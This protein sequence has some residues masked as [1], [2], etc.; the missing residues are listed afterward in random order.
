MRIDGGGARGGDEFAARAPGRGRMTAAGCGALLAALAVTPAAWAQPVSTALHWVRL[1][2]AETCPDGAAL[3]RLVD[4]RLGR[5]TFTAPSRAVRLLEGRIGPRASTPGWEVVITSYVDG[6]RTG[7]RTLLAARAD[8]AA[9]APTLGLVLTLLA[10]PDACGDGA[11]GDPHA[12]PGVGEATAPAVLRL[13]AAAPTPAPLMPPRTRWT[14]Y[15]GGGAALLN[16]LPSG[17][18]SAAALWRPRAGPLAVEV[19][20]S[21]LVPFGGAPDA[22]GAVAVRA[23]GGLVQALGCVS[24]FDDLRLSACVGLTGGLLHVT[25]LGP[26]DA[27]DQL[28]PVLAG[29]ARVAVQA[30]LGERWVVRVAPSL[31]VPL[32]WPRHVVAV[33]GD[34]PREVQRPGAAGVSLEASVGWRF[35]E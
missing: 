4:A 35:G 11:C 32:R 24:P 34:A 30:S 31:V 15:L 27:Q 6:A 29:V 33:D 12:L 26:V 14:V 16:V 5:P 13:L 7:T 22:P 3:A 18:V 23:Y 9:V 20:L 19:G 2:G 17:A 25:A 21:G 8:C 28:D 10:D 1:P